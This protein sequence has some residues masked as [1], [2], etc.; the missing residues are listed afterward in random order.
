MS[1]FFTFNKSVYDFELSP[2]G[3]LAYFGKV[4]QFTTFQKPSLL[5]A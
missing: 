1:S 4:T 2:K 3:Y 5:D